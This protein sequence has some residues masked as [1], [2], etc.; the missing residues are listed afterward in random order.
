LILINK[1]EIF[2]FYFTHKKSR[3]ELSTFWGTDHCGGGGTQ[4][5][6]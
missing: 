1:F 5:E 2:K 4:L 3:H 6:R